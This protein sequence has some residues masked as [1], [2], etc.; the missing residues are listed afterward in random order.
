MKYKNIFIKKRILK[1]ISLCSIILILNVVLFAGINLKNPVFAK[2][3]DKYVYV[4]GDAIGLKVDI[5][6]FVAGKYQVVTDSGKLSPW[7]NSNIEKGDKIISF[8]DQKINS[9]KELLELLK[10]YTRSSAVLAI[11]RGTSI[12]NTT[13]DIVKTKNGEQTMGLYVKDR[14]LGIGTVTFIDPDTMKFASLGHGINDDTLGY[15]YVSGDILETNIESVKKAVPGT[16]GEKRASLSSKV[17]GALCYNGVTGV[18]GKVSPASFLGAERER[19]IAADQ[20]EV[21]KGKAYIRTVIDGQKINNYEVEI[22]SVVLQK[23]N[24]VK[25]IKIKITDERLISKTGG[26]IQGMSG[27]PIIQNNMIVGAVSHVSIDDPTIGYGMHIE[28]ML[29]D[30]DEFVE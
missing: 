3:D 1:I 15:G 14:L 23:T 25:G 28:W 13:I 16:T 12:F 27:S 4:G 22:L 10:R 9:N 24:S 7:K 19:L 5:G 6:I 21:K 18:Y 30:L 8:N 17:L 20:D 26:I 29:E 2:D 11:K